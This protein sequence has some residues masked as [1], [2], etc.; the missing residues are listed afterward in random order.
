MLARAFLLL[1]LLRRAAL[2]FPFWLGLW[3]L[4]MYYVALV[5]FFVPL[6][7]SA[8]VFQIIAGISFSVIQLFAGLFIP[9]SQMGAWSFM[10]YAVGSSWALKFM[11]VPQFTCFTTPCPTIVLPAPTGQGFVTVPLLSFIL[12]TF[13]VTEEGVNQWYSFGYLILIST[14][15]RLLSILAYRFINFTKR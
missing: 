12:S 14:I 4:A 6:T 11:A 15:I 5:H 8:T 9:V 13:S 7:P 1:L 10:Y 2:F 3:G